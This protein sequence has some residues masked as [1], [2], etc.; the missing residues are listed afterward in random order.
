MSFWDTSSQQK[1]VETFKALTQTVDHQQ[2][3]SMEKI[4][5]ITKENE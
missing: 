5:V 4:N 3:K 1:I 2:R